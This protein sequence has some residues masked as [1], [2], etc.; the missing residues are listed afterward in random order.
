MYS[1]FEMRKR[2]RNAEMCAVSVC[3]SVIKGL[4][5]SFVSA[6]SFVVLNPK[7]GSKVGCIRG[8]LTFS[9][10]HGSNSGEHRFKYPLVLC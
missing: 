8:L 10:R 9:W 7:Y 4:C 5:L 2:E 6:A 3:L 1:S